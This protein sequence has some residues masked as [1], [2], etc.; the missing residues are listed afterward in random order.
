MSNFV[1]ALAFVILAALLKYSLARLTTKTNFFQSAMELPVD[2]L[3][4]CI[5][6]LATYMVMISNLQIEKILE[7]IKNGKLNTNN[8]NTDNVKVSLPFFQTI[9]GVVILFIFYFLLVSVVIICW[10]KSEEYFNF[11]GGINIISILITGLG[12]LLTLTSIIFVIFL[13]KAV[14]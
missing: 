12:Y 10:R 4:A 11:K 9:E 8:L 7:V 13:I 6:F 5:A 1:I 3:F 14:Q 2:L